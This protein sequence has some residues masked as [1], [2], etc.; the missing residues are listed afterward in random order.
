MKRNRTTAHYAAADLF[1]NIVAQ[2]E[3]GNPH[4]AELRAENVEEA[5]RDVAQ[6]LGF[7]VARA[8]IAKLEAAE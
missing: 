3:C 2:D 1:R 8:E 4:L 7:T 5:L 6:A